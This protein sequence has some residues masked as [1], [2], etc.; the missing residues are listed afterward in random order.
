M[1]KIIETKSWRAFGHKNFADY[2]LDHTSDGLGVNTNQRLWI[3]RCSMDVHGGHMKEWAD[4]LEK[5]EQMVRLE[6][7][8]DG[9]TIRSFNGQSLEELAKNVS[10]VGHERITYLPS[11]HSHHDGHLVRLRK[12]KPDVFR[13]VVT[14][15]MTMVEARRAAG[16]AVAKNTNVGR[17]QSAF[18]MMTKKERK[19]FLDWL[20]TEGFLET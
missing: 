10:H 4:V 17:A 3:L 19:E 6:A 7:K 2:A 9:D 11:R 15:E 18:R 20:R 13:K 5:V 14:G 8:R 1:A 16:M 12:N